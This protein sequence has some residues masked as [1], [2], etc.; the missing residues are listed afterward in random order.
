MK[1]DLPSLD[2]GKYSKLWWLFWSSFQ[3]ED[4]IHIYSKQ[5]SSHKVC[6]SAFV[7]VVF[8]KKKGNCAR[9][10][11]KHPN[12]QARDPRHAKQRVIRHSQKA[13]NGKNFQCPCMSVHVDIVGCKWF[14]QVTEYRR[15]LGSRA[16]WYRVS[17]GRRETEVEI[18]VLP[19]NS[20]VTGIKLLNLSEPLFL[21]L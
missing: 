9:K 6:F 19:F 14:K 10:Q 7:S 20:H 2:I 18:L 5:K 16:E 11:K 3:Q 4:I 12:N 17:L 21:H 8:A 13:Y 15:L 1:C